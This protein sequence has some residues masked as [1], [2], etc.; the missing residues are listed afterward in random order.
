MLLA[1]SAKLAGLTICLG[2]ACIQTV[3]AQS[4]DGSNETI[5]E[6]APKLKP[7]PSLQ[8]CIDNLKEG[9]PPKDRA[10]VWSNEPRN[11]EL[12]G[13]WFRNL[14]IFQG[15]NNLV[16]ANDGN[17]WKDPEFLDTQRYEGSPLEKM[18]FSQHYRQ[19]WSAAATGN[20]FL[21]MP[22]TEVPNENLLFWNVQWPAF[23]KNGKVDKIIWVSMTSFLCLHPILPILLYV[24]LEWWRKGDS[25]PLAVPDRAPRSMRQLYDDLYT[26]LHMQPAAAGTS[27]LNVQSTSTTRSRPTI[28]ST[29]SS[30]T[31]GKARSGL[32]PGFFNP[33]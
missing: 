3:L 15:M 7:Y 22:R 17:N 19:V 11:S 25:A 9:W 1:L 6:R 23:E 4:A 18:I 31:T 8:D 12:E 10:I 16:A 24:S 29:A 5:T 20:V 30:T 32:R 13:V 21:V 28:T 2:F 26:S 33:P 14:I 27:T